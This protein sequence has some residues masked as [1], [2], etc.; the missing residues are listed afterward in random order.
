MDKS[1]D[2]TIALYLD[3]IKEKF[4]DIERVFLFGS[5][6]IAPFGETNSK[7]ECQS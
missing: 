2:T 1:I 3:L 6:T 5:Q 4:I 7:A